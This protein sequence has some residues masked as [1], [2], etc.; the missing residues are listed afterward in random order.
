MGLFGSRRYMELFDEERGKLDRLLAPRPAAAAP[1]GPEAHEAVRSTTGCLRRNRASDDPRAEAI[2]VGDFELRDTDRA[3]LD[4]CASATC[5]AVCSRRRGAPRR[6]AGRSPASGAAPPLTRRGCYRRGRDAL[7][8]LRRRDHRPCRRGGELDQAYGAW[9]RPD[10]ERRFSFARRRDPAA[11]RAHCSRARLDEIAPPGPVLDVG[12]GEGTLIDALRGRGR[13]ARRPR[14]RR[15]GA[16]TC[17]TSRS[18]R[19]EGEGTG[20]RSSSGTRSSTFRTPGEAIRAGRRL[21]APG[22]RGR[23]RGAQHDSLQARA[24][25]DSLA[26]PR[27]PPPPRPPLQRLAARR[28]GALRLRVEPR[29]ARCAAGRS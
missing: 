7:R 25:G 2:D 19:I 3:A 23:R 8:A 5:C 10:S 17:A 6:A 4:V 26:P 14:A 27:P 13:E 24:F 29:L 11:A 16:P 1:P 9:Y 28:L 12:A 20:R 22:R 15:H 21:L 18:T